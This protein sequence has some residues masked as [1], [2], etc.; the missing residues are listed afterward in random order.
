[1]KIAHFDFDSLDNPAG[2]G[3]A[4]RTFEIYRRLADRHSI[5]VYTGRSSTKAHT[6]DGIRFVPLGLRRFPFNAPSFIAAM[7]WQAHR[8]EAD[9]IGEDF[10]VPC[11]PSGLPL[12][13]RVPVVG[14]AQFFFAPQLAAKYH[15][16]FDAVERMMIRHYRY[17]I[18]GT[19]EAAKRA[20]SLAPRSQIYVIINGVDEEAFLLHDASEG[21]CAFLGRLDRH[22]KGLDRLLAVIEQT[23]PRVTF[24]IA[25][26]GPDKDWLEASLLQRGLGDRVRLVGRLEGVSRLRFL[27]R[28]RSVVFPSRYETLALIPFEAAAT[29]RPVIGFA[30]NGME[31]TFR[32][33]E[34]PVVRTVEECSSTI[35]ALDRDP[36]LGDRLGS[37]GRTRMQAFTWDE[38]ARKQEDIMRIAASAGSP[39]SVR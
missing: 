36:P 15:V 39:R 33:L 5:T 20:Q 3:Q 26:T 25:G 13:A 19:E 16:P 24:R 11:G 34:Q 30:G 35:D 12:H 28:A 38:A 22:Q 32:S 29:G 1:M 23:D 14:V 7:Q 18:T 31:T 8:A 4:R 2:G 37:L 17:I 10:T 6:R 21:Y 9:V 27:R